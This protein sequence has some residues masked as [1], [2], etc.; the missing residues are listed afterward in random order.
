M[1]PLVITV[2]CVLVALVALAT[3]LAI[4]L[5]GSRRRVQDRDEREDNLDE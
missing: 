3:V 4:F 1:T 5:V 2:I